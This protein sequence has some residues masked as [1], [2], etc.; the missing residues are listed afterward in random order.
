MSQSFSCPEENCGLKVTYVPQSLPGSIGFNVR[1]LDPP[2]EVVV[3]LT[4]AN[5]HTH[6]YTVKVGSSHE[7]HGG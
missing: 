2:R 3:Y 7:K 5:G 4:C 1:K 6:A